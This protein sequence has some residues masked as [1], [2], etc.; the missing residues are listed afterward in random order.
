MFGGGSFGIVTGCSSA[1]ASWS[2]EDEAAT[3]RGRRGSD[4]F[5]RGTSR[6]E[7]PYT[8]TVARLGCARRNCAMASAGEFILRFLEPKR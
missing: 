4:A 5:T 8:L 3:G 7:E 2:T 1:A 6:H